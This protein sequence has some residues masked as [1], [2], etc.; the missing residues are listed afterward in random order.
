MTLTYD[1]NGQVAMVTGAAAGMGVATAR[2]FAAAGASVVLTDINQDAVEKA[3]RE[4]SER[5][6]QVLP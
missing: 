1:F 4:L 5:G 2:A 3:T 6:C